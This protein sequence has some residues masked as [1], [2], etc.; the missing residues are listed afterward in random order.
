MGVGLLG[1]TP[2]AASSHDTLKNAEITPDGAIVATDDDFVIAGQDLTV[3]GGTF[4]EGDNGSYVIYNDGYSGT[5]SDN[6]LTVSDVAQYSYPDATFGIRVDGGEVTV[7]DNTVAASDSINKL[8]VAIGIANGAT[9]KVA[10]NEIAGAHRGGVLAVDSGTEVSVSNNTMVGPGPRSSG[11][12]DNGVQISGGATGSVRANTIT[13]HWYSPNT[14]VSSGLILFSDEVVVQRNHFEN[15]D[16]AAG[17]IGDRNNLIQNTVEVTYTVTDTSHYG[18]IEYG[19]RNNGI[20]QNSISTEAAENGVAGIW[21]TGENA[22]L[23]RNHL[24]GWENP[25]VDGG[26]ETKLPK[27]FDPNA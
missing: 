18:F 4:Y 14:Y 21:V 12:A 27:P 16:L 11:W 9:A 6:T 3:D 22:K 20:R 25:L 24:A 15:N 17:L 1:T 2:V 5:I 26:D 10:G 23:I 13:D 7:T 19:G 8:F